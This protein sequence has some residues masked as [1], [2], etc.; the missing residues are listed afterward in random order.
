MLSPR[1]ILQRC[2]GRKNFMLPSLWL[3]ASTTAFLPQSCAPDTFTPSARSAVYSF[4]FFSPSITLK[5]GCSLSAQK[6]SIKRQV[7]ALLLVTKGDSLTSVLFQAS[8]DPHFLP[9]CC[10][11]SHFIYFFSF[12]LIHHPQRGWWR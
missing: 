1:N 8:R 10:I 4:L 9:P 2:V 3:P 7:F 12:F 11:Q 6:L 5:D